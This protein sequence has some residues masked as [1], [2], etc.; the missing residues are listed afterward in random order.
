VV[1]QAPRRCGNP[2]KVTGTGGSLVMVADGEG[3]EG[4]PA[5][6]F[7]RWGWLRWLPVRSCSTRGGGGVVEA[8]AQAPRRCGNPGKVT[9]TGGSLVMVADGEGVPAAAFQRWGWLRW[10][11]VRSCSTRGGGGGGGA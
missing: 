2:G 9:G 1:A 8:V 11:P 5:A 6:A 10:L 3:V 7:Q 4:V